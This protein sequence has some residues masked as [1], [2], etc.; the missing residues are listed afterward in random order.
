MMK[1]N[2][3]K[4]HRRSIRLREYDYS[5]AGAY[6]VTICTKDR[7]SIFG[8]IAGGEMRLNS[9]GKMVQTCW[10]DL[11]R[12]YPHVELDAFVIMP[13]H[14]HGIVVLTYV[15]AGLKPAPTHGLSEIIRGLKTFS[16]RRIN[17]SRNTVGTPLWQRNYYEH[18]IRNE[19][20][21]DNIR[22]Y[23]MDNPIKWG[24][25]ENNP[26]NIGRDRSVCL[27]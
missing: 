25:D 11:P 8:E 20:D 17:D 7:E 13:N 3:D 22:Q 24:E 10:L 1:Y 4:H 2:P 21:L 15:G 12:H 26:R 27:P 23:I 16:S 9:F 19:T 18:I 5:Q 14:I 6:F